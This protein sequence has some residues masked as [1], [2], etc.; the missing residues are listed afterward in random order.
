[1]VSHGPQ[2]IKLA[3]ISSGFVVIYIAY[4]ART[5]SLSSAIL[6]MASNLLGRGV[7]QRPVRTCTQCKQVKVSRTSAETSEREYQT[8]S[9]NTL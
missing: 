4:L 6:A 8:G 5:V 3:Q 7:L 2:K 1:M 9:S